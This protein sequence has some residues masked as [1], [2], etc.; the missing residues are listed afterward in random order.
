VF[1]LLGCLS[2]FGKLGMTCVGRNAEEAA[3]VYNATTERLIGRAAAL[4]QR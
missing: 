4:M 2:E 3:S 1:H